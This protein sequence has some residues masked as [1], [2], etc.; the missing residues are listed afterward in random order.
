MGSACLNKSDPKYTDSSAETVLRGLN[1]KERKQ[2]V[3]R[4]YI[5]YMGVRFR[6]EPS[7]SFRRIS[8]CRCLQ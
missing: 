7:H 5:I 2:A 8:L 3:H 6:S 4:C 1:L